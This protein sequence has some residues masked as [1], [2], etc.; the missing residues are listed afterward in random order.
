[1]FKNRSAELGEP[2][3]SLFVAKLDN[4]TFSC[5]VRKNITPINRILT[6]NPINFNMV[7]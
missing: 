5:G 3:I 7:L 2:K 6:I 4:P 1:M